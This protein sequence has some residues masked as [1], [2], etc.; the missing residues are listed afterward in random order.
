[1]ATVTAAELAAANGGTNLS[2]KTLTVSPPGGETVSVTTSVMSGGIVRQAPL[3]HVGNNN[4]I[5]LAGSG[6]GVVGGATIGS[7][8]YDFM[9][10]TADGTVEPGPNQEVGAKD[11]AF[12]INSIN[13]GSSS[14]GRWQDQVTIT[15]YDAN[16]NAIVG[17]VSAVAY[18]TTSGS[19]VPTVTT[20]ADGSVVITGSF[21]SNNDHTG[22]DIK[23]NP[24]GQF[25]VAYFVIGYKNGGTQMVPAPYI[26]IEP[27]SYTPEAIICF[28]A[29]TIVET[30]RGL[31]AVED[32]SVGDLVRTRDHGLQPVRWIARNAIKCIPEKFRPIRIRAGA[33]AENTPSSDLLVS[34]QHRILV[35]S[36]IAQKMFGTSEVLVA[37]KQLLQIDGIDVAQDLDDV[38]Y[39]HFL[40][41]DHQIVFSNGTET[42]SLYTGAEALKSVGQAARAEIFALFPELAD[43]DD[44]PAAARPLVSGR[45]GRR[46][47]V[48]HAQH[49]KPLVM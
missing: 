5:E 8:K 30:D 48:R 3:P 44:A 47:A 22:A 21:N 6:S 45:M 39:V 23:I 20:S 15:A 12:R 32:L 16:G 25:D 27:V 33:L 29:G 13:G 36:A 10:N 31:V 24:D 43:R 2:N 38:T 4:T 41:D 37:A 46:L 42:E 34:P 18:N 1:M 28:V 35:R 19:R 11:V 9:D 40:F 26:Y 17:A 49:R 7:I 14:T